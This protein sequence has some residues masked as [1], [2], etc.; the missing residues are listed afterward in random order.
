M[1]DYLTINGE[2]SELLIGNGFSSPLELYFKGKQNKSPFVMAS[3][4]NYRGHVAEWKVHRDKLYLI[5]L[6]VRA[7]QGFEM[8]EPY[9]LQKVFPA[10]NKED[11]VF[12]NWFSGMLL[13]LEGAHKVYPRNGGYRMEYKKY[14]IL[15]LRKG[16]V[17]QNT[18]LTRKE[19]WAA[20]TPSKT[21]EKLSAHRKL[22]KAYRDSQVAA[23]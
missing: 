21:D 18:G 4:A 23:E 12:A 15:T 3:T 2:R 13:I 17:T 7:G 14:R 20:L 1:P 16:V 9:D 19:Y 8:N 10:S 5:G 11:G 22:L 6:K